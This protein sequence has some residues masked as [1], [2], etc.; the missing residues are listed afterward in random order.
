MSKLSK[1]RARARK[2]KYAKPSLPRPIGANDNHPAAVNDNEEQPFDLLREPGVKETPNQRIF[3]Q[4][5][6]RALDEQAK[7][8]ISYDPSRLTEH[9]I[10]ELRRAEEKL[11]SGDPKRMAS[12]KNTVLEIARSIQNRVEGHE[13]ALHQQ[14]FRSLEE[15]RG[16]VF[17]EP[18]RNEPPGRMR[19]SSR[20]GLETLF[21]TH[22]ISRVHHA[23]GLM[24]RADYERIDPEKLLTPPQLDP[25]KVS[26]SHGGDNWDTKRREIEERVF[27]IHLMICGVDAPTREERRSLPRWPA[28][29]PAMRAIHALEQIAGKGLNLGDLTASGSV[30]ARLR[31]DLI[32]AL[33]ACAIVYGLE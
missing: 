28:G 5:M 3:R 33:D 21:T 25:E 30:K 19:I 31:E 23:A 14:E 18:S 16:S 8:S 1:Q 29:H 4:M 32:F 17:A 12:G 22:S 6:R 7:P 15:L 26:V 10:K 9:Q 24:Y 2:A 20:D 27:G 11:T 13:R